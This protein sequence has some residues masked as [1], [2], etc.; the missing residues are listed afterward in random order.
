MPS[1]TIN[2]VVVAFIVVGHIASI[3]TVDSTRM[4]NSTSNLAITSSIIVTVIIAA[5]T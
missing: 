4:P 3:A 5:A 2:L 1:L